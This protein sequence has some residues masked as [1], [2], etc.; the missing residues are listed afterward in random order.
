MGWSVKAPNRG[1]VLSYTRYTVGA[2]SQGVKPRS[3]FVFIG[4]G[5]VWAAVSQGVK[6]RSS[7]VFILL[8]LLWPADS[9]GVKQR[10]PVDMWRFFVGGAIRQFAFGDL[11][12][13]KR[14]LYSS[15]Y[16]VHTR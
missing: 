12:E 16:Q 8:G 13:Q 5:L 1:L 3:C 6:P 7:F 2:V 15:I 10:A 14:L 11:N 9:Q 4:R